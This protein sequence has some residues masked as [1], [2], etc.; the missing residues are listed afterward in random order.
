M[1]VVVEESFTLT[2]TVTHSGSGSDTQYVSDTY[3]AAYLWTSYSLVRTASTSSLYSTTT[4]SVTGITNGIQLMVKA[5]GDAT[6]TVTLVAYGARLVDE[7][8]GV[9]SPA[10]LRRVSS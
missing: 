6:I 10:L 1:P 5:T 3:G 2:L 4:F 7:E 9:R 8:P